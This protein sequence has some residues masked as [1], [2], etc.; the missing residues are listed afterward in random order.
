MRPTFPEHSEQNILTRREVSQMLRVSVHSL[1][2]NRKAWSTFLPLIKI[3]H[4]IRYRLSDV[5]N[6]LNHGNIEIMTTSCLEGD[7][8]A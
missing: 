2:V 5:E 1:C 8:E 6:I 3:G 7:D 4:N